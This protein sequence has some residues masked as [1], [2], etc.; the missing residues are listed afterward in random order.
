MHT[1]SSQ[2]RR[3]KQ[4]QKSGA[5]RPGLKQEVLL[6]PQVL[7]TY[8]CITCSYK[9]L[10]MHSYK[11]YSRKESKNQSKLHLNLIIVFYV[12]LAEEQNL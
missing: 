4:F 7:C 12:P 1:H 11:Q 9:G 6:C 8:V 10:A 3:Q 2:S 5:H